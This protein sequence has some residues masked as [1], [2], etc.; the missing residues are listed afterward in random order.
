MSLENLAK[1]GR[2][3]PHA[4]TR[5]EITKLLK[6][7]ARCLKDAENVSVSGAARF[8]LAYTVIMEAALAAMLANGY[9]PSKSEGGH[10]MTLIQALVHTIGIQ[11]GRMRVLDRH[12]HMRNAIEYSGEDIEDSQLQSALAGARALLADVKKW[13]A[14]NRP[15]LA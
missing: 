5:T 10:H 15:E 2:L 9:R 14:K 7:A 6:G 1:I 4:A 13:I 12:R 8:T 11:S 3:Q